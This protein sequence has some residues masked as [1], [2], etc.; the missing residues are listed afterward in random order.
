M[1]DYRRNL[2]WTREVCS[3]DPKEIWDDG[4]QGHN[5]SYGIEPELLS[6]ASSKSVD[7]MMYRQMICA[8]IYLMDTRPDTCFSMNT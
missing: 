7:A 1:L 3:R 8:L 4:M 5:H 6:D 2:P